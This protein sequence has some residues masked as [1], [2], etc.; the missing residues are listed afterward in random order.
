MIGR[1]LVVWW[2]AMIGVAF[3]QALLDE[4]ELV[5]SLA[6]TFG[7]VLWVAVVGVQ[8]LDRHERLVAARRAAGDRWRR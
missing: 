4:P 2:Y 5:M 6:V 8:W 3:S 7:V 1:A